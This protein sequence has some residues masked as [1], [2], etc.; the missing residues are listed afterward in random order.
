MTV[1]WCNYCVG[2]TT[3][4]TILMHDVKNQFSH[5]VFDGLA[6]DFALSCSAPH[7]HTVTILLNHKLLQTVQACH[8]VAKL[9]DRTRGPGGQVAK[10]VDTGEQYSSLILSTW[11]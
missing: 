8:Q 9:V 7:N 11:L 6:S 1:Q 10:L 5:P 2:Q 4:L 3:V